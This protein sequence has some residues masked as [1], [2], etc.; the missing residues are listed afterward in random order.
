[1]ILRNRGELGKVGLIFSGGGG[2]DGGSL[3]SDG[4]LFNGCLYPVMLEVSEYFQHA[5]V[6][7]ASIR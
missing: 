4:I 1:M 5:H 6:R 3:S 7:L 2:G